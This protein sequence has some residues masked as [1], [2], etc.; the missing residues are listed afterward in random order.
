MNH[1]PDFKYFITSGSNLINI[2]N[3]KSCEIIKQYYNQTN[4]CYCIQVENKLA[5][6]IKPLINS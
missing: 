1:S 3:M 4:I 5:K 6:Q 2:Y